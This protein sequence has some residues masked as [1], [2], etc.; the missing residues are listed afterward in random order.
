MPA[1][2]T[3][4]RGLAGAVAAHQRH[5]LAA[6]DPEGKAAQRRHHHAVALVLLEPER[7]AR[8]QPLLQRPRADVVERE[9]DG[10]AFGPD[11]RH[12]G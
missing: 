12:G 1:R 6:L 9:F 8:Q 2:R 3:Q 11:V 10:Q 5:P 7:R 4:Q